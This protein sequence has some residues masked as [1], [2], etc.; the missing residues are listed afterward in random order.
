LKKNGFIHL[1]ELKS[2]CSKKDSKFFVEKFDGHYASMKTDAGNA[3]GNVFHDE[4]GIVSIWPRVRGD[5]R[6]FSLKVPRPIFISISLSI[7][8][9]GLHCLRKV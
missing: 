2:I 5:N 6:A 4:N 3:H 7:P 8:Y 1:D 9:S